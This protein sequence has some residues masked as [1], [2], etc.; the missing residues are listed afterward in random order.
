VTKD[1]V[2]DMISTLV[3]GDENADA[4]ARI[5]AVMDELKRLEQTMVE[6]FVDKKTVQF[7]LKACRDNIFGNML[8]LGERLVKNTYIESANKKYHFGIRED[9]KFGIYRSNDNTRYVWS[10]SVEGN[11]EVSNIIGKPDI[12]IAAYRDFGKKPWKTENGDTD[13]ISKYSNYPT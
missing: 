8:V 7:G 1:K 6:C 3:F 5:D 2:V 9:G 13:L 11:K 12:S 4:V 10:P